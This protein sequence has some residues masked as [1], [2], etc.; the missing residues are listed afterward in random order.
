ML[1]CF[2]FSIE[3]NEL[4]EKLE[5][6]LERKHTDNYS[7][8]ELLQILLQGEKPE[9]FEK[10]RHNKLILLLEKPCPLVRSY[11]TIFTPSNAHAH[12]SYMWACALD[13]LKKGN[14]N[15]N[16]NNSNNN[17]NNNNEEEEELDD[18]DDKE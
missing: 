6:V 16:A 5:G 4:F 11:P 3:R 18:D 15:L 8:T 1:D 7:K 17:N 14:N 10:Y 2:I 13:F 12:Q 9:I